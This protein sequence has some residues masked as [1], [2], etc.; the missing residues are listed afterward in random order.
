ML[1]GSQFFVAVL[2]ALNCIPRI[3]FLAISKTLVRFFFDIRIFG[4][5]K[6]SLGGV[7]RYLDGCQFFAAIL[8]PIYCISTI[9]FLAI[10]KTIEFDIFFFDF[11]YFWSK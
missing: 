6:D 1:G 9:K 5:K 11:S 4:A 7:P 8:C 10:S 3:T 2:Y